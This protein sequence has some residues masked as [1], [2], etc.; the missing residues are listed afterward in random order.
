MKQQLLSIL[1]QQGQTPIINS[2]EQSIREF[3]Q[4]HYCHAEIKETIREM[5]F[6]IDGK[7]DSYIISKGY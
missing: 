2:I 1:A 5:F 4:L 7:I 3:K 6:G